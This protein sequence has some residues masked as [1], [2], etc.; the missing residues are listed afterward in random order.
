[1]QEEVQV[2]AFRRPN[3]H[4]ED[5]AQGEVGMDKAGRALALCEHVRRLTLPEDRQIV[6]RFRGTETSTGP[7]A[8]GR[9]SPK[10][11]ECNVDLLTGRNP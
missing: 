5:I 6:A 8:W 9:N 3:L 7:F 1:M 10:V 11:E 2:R 4:L